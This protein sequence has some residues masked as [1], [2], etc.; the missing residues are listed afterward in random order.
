MGSNTSYE[1]S[2]YLYK[3]EKNDDVLLINLQNGCWH[4]ISKELY[5]IIQEFIDSKTSIDRLMDTLADDE[6]RKLIK[7]VI[8]VLCN[9]GIIK[10]CKKKEKHNFVFTF[11]ITNKCNLYCR[12]CSYNAQYVNDSNYSE[13]LSTKEIKK[14]FEE[15]L[16]LKPKAI[17]LTGGEPLMRKDFFE[18]LIYLRNRYNGIISIMTNGT[19][20]S[21]ENVNLLAHYASQ[22][23][24]SIDGVNEYTC[25]QIRGKGVFEKVINAVDLLH[26]E[27]FTNISLSMVDSRITHEYISDFYKLNKKLN[28]FPVVRDFTPFGRGEKNQSELCIREN[29]KRDDKN[30]HCNLEEKK[31]FQKKILASRCG[32][33]CGS[34][35]IDS[36]GQIYGCATLRELGYKIG[37]PSDSFNLSVLLPKI[38]NSNLKMQYDFIK[39]LPEKCRECDVNIFCLEC[40][41]DVLRIKDEMEFEKFC[42]IRKKAF[43]ELI[44]RI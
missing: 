30:R 6:D 25:S 32:A 4:R 38:V 10:E 29:A 1:F 17:S 15:M 31:Q 41:A 27:G 36:D 24:I 14:I 11:A 12:H 20:I 18:L 42:E 35:F 13:R 43:E 19:L 26:N 37:G 39:D 3:M 33:G 40:V 34:F 8:D 7:K 23:D 44:W 5:E 16:R 9:Y 2:K 22:I 21:K 28:T